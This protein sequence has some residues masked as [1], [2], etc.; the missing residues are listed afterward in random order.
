MARRGIH[1]FLRRITLLLK[2]LALYLIKVLSLIFIRMSVQFT[3][4]NKASNLELVG[5]ENLLCGHMAVWIVQ[6]LN[7][8]LVIGRSR[9]H[10]AHH[11]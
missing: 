4:A 2:K 10:W 11:V 5:D 3:L 9:Y 6:N 7:R 1:R 8:L